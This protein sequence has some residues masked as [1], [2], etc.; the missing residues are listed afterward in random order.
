MEYGRAYNYGGT[1]EHHVI[2]VVVVCGYA[3]SEAIITKMW[4]AFKMRIFIPPFPTPHP[5]DGTWHGAQEIN[6][7]VFLIKKNGKLCK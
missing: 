1:I 6:W 3:E 7:K 5:R 4:R 2:P